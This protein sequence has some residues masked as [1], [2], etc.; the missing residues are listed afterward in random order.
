MGY[1]VA[2]LGA[3]VLLGGWVLD[4]EILRSPFPE[5]ASV[6]PLAAVGFILLGI[7]TQLA[8]QT[9]HRLRGASN[10]TASL[11][12]LLVGYT[13]LAAKIGN[14]ALLL[15][16]TYQQKMTEV[17]GEPSIGTLL[18]F[19]LLSGASLIRSMDIKTRGAGIAAMMFAAASFAGYL[20]EIPELYWR[21]EGISTAMPFYA[22]C[23]IGLLGWKY[24]R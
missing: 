14:S 4:L 10:A 7:S 18:C 23:F 11:T 2:I 1:L 22:A 12:I 24:S 8:S 17:P 20:F 19:L 6:K 13:A 3:A 16:D 15:S 9:S 5:T 21:V